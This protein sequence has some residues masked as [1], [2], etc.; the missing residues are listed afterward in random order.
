MAD[1]RAVCRSAGDSIWRY[2]DRE[3]EKLDAIVVS[4][5][6]DGPLVLFRRG[7]NRAHQVRL[8]TKNR[9]WA[10]CAFQFAHE[11]C[12]ITCNHRNVPNAQMWFEESMCE[13]AS[14][15]ALRQ[16]ARTWKTKPPYAN[17]KSYAKALDSYAEKRLQKAKLP[18]RLSLAAWYKRHRLELEEK[19]TERS[20]NLMIAAQVLP[21]L[22]RR[23]ERWQALRYINRGDP[24]ENKTFER[25]LAGWH[26]RVP[27]KHKEFVREVGTLFGVVLESK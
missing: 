21:L 11:F 20:R 2:M 16:M 23:P 6:K 18:D 19:G 10:Q 1:V 13:C 7:K 17:W 22:E 15:F 4:Y 24:A 8:D 12:H 27:K 25:Y 26:E 3:K 14:L 5:G 9:H